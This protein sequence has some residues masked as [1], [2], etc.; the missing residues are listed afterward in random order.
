MGLRDDLIDPQKKQERWREVSGWLSIGTLRVPPEGLKIK[1]RQEDDKSLSTQQLAWYEAPKAADPLTVKHP[2][3]VTVS[4][5]SAVTDEWPNTLVS[6]RSWR[7]A[8]QE[9]AYVIAVTNQG[10]QRVKGTHL[11]VVD[12]RLPL[13]PV[14][15]S[16]DSGS[17]MEGVSLPDATGSSPP[18]LWFLPPI[19]A[20]ETHVLRYRVRSGC[21][22]HIIKGTATISEAE[23]NLICLQPNGTFEFAID[24]FNKNQLDLIYD[25][26][27]TRLTPEWPEI[28]TEQQTMK[29]ATFEATSKVQIKWD[30]RRFLRSLG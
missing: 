6:E 24:V 9:M 12:T 3:N 16:A 4:I 22:I 2:P 19:A 5:Y 14:S 29:R 30:G 25:W 20:G 26:A 8:G 28:T 17:G 7:S 10:E 21:S 23:P 13:L 11:Q 27:A 18:L 15:V 1:E